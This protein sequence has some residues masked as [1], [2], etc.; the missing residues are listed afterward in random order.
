MAR[1]KVKLR[2][3]S[4][5]TGEPLVTMTAE[6]LMPLPPPL[7]KKEAEPPI[8]LLSESQRKN[9]ESSLDGISALMLPKPKDKQ[10]E[11]KLVGR[12]LS[13]LKKL[14]SQEDKWLFWQPLIQN[15]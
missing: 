13:G 2:D 1:S 6:D 4:R 14:L 12:F 8:P 9:Y 5:A 7:E 3:V 11:E 10:E 15:L